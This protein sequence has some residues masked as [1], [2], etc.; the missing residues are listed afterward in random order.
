MERL[1]KLDHIFEHLMIL[2]GVIFATLFQY[3]VWVWPS[4]IKEPIF[5]AI[6]SFLLPLIITLLVWMFG[7]IS[8]YKLFIRMFCWVWGLSTLSVYTLFILFI[9][10][11]PLGD[12]ASIYAFTIVAIFI[13][14]LMIFY[15]KIKESYRVAIPYTEY[16]TMPWYKKGTLIALLTF[17]AFIIVCVTYSYNIPSLP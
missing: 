6:T 3:L 14:I 17:V 4:N 13:I 5:I 10:L 12:I 15:D 11:F 16:W 9:S 1:Q 7:L 2:L 8:E